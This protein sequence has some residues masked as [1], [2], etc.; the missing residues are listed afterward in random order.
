MTT[1]VVPSDI[2]IAQS[3]KLRHI[4]AVAGD[5]GLGH[6]DIDQYGR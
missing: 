2:E 6:D 5:L 3:A 4:T 1:V